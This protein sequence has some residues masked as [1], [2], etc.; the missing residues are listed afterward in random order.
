MHICL[1]LL[2]LEFTNICFKTWQDK[3]FES[4]SLMWGMKNILFTSVKAL[5]NVRPSRCGKRGVEYY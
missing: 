4:V 1:C 2:S 3:F 5:P